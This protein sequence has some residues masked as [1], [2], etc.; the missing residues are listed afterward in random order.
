MG[1]FEDPRLPNSD[2]FEF[3]MEIGGLSVEREKLAVSEQI[4]LDLRVLRTNR[5]ES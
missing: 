4:C 2:K 5:K 3:V 1:K